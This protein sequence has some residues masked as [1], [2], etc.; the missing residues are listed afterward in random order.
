MDFRLQVC[1]LV[2]CV[3]VVVVEG[4]PQ[5]FQNF[6][7]QRPVQQQQRQNFQQQRPVQQNFQQQR[8]VQ[9]QQRPAQQQQQSNAIAPGRRYPEWLDTSDGKYAPF[10]GPVKGIPRD[11]GGGRFGAADCLLC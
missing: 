3:V 1:V 10:N 4:A 11:H 9:Q 6:Q 8:P 7:Q 5:R 2:I